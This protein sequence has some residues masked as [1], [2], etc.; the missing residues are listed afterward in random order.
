VSG[1]DTDLELGWKEREEIE[2][3]LGAQSVYCNVNGPVSEPPIL[4]QHKEFWINE[5]T[6]FV[7]VTDISANPGLQS[8]LD[9]WAGTGFRVTDI[10]KQVGRFPSLREVLEEKK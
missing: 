4:R 8:F 7:L 1:T 5:Q 9:L 2:C 6:Q 3:L 10:K